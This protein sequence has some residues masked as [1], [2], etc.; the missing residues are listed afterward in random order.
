[1]RVIIDIGHP[2]HVHLFKHLAVELLNK[3]HKVFFTCREKEFEIELLESFGLEYKSMGH[4]KKG[5][6]FKIIGL[7]YFTF[8]MTLIALKFKP[9]IFLSHGSMYAAFSAFILGKDHISLEDTFNF[10]QINLYKPFTRAILT[11]DYEH[12]LKSTKVIKYS[13]YHE[14]AYLHPARFKPESFL[15]NYVIPEGLIIIRFISWEAS[16]DI[17]H[18][19]ISL[20]NKFR[21]VDKLSQFGEVII[22]SEAE[23]PY[24]LHKFK[25]NYPPQ[26]MHYILAR[27]KLLFTESGTMAAEAAVLGVPSIFID[28]DHRIYTL[29]LEKRYK[30][31]F[32]FTES[33][34]DQERA[35]SLAVDL[36]TDHN[37]GL[38]WQERRKKM[39]NEKIDV[40]SFLSWFIETYPES[41][42]IMKSN[43]DFQTNFIGS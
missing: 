8:K 20:E 33:E 40:T 34:R 30:L 26:M 24:E 38:I 4:K 31:C 15:S 42:T 9:D 10:E 27:S 39:L 22:S 16:H 12:P 7:L 1:M 28:N 43:P 5:I 17:G 14:L 41:I 36:L 11:A 2:A 32:N 29:E 37:T 18:T 23:L 6:L 19:G 13:G 21:I 3:R 25:N 35:L